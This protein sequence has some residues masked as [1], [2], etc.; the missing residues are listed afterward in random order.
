MRNNKIPVHAMSSGSRLLIV[1]TLSEVK[2]IRV[3]ENIKV[4]IVSNAV[5][6]GWTAKEYRPTHVLVL[7]HSGESV[8]QNL[9][10]LL[11]EE[12]GDVL[13]HA[14]SQIELA[15]AWINKFLSIAEAS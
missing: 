11:K 5:E 1:S 8:A 3:P 12:N 4:S 7:D 9:S 14:T 13:V 6:A 2:S 10:S 15:N